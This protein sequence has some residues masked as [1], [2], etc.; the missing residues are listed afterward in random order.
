[1]PVLNFSTTHTHTYQTQHPNSLMICWRSRLRL[2][3]VRGYCGLQLG[4][5][6]APSSPN[7]PPAHRASPPACSG[8]HRV[9]EVV[10]P[11][12]L[13]CLRARAGMAVVL[14]CIH[15]ETRCKSSVKTLVARITTAAVADA[16]R[17]AANSGV[18]VGLM[19][20]QDLLTVEFAAQPQSP[21]RKCSLQPLRSTPPAPSW[22][23]YRAM[24][25]PI[26]TSRRCQS[27]E[28]EFAVGNF[29]RGWPVEPTG[30]QA[31]VARLSAESAPWPA[32]SPNPGRQCCPP[33]PRPCEPAGSKADAAD[34]G[35]LA[36]AVPHAPKSCIFSFT[37]VFSPSPVTFPCFQCLIF[38]YLTCLSNVS[39]CTLCIC[40]F[41]SLSHS[42]HLSSVAMCCVNSFCSMF[43][44]LLGT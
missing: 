20:P 2:S 43:S 7:C 11:R 10:T 17:K 19:R 15:N 37:C 25:V 40:V 33:S 12:T 32:P 5:T 21:A 34:V 44:T 13:Q 31:R 38:L 14:R 35:L 27:V 28:A 8:A 39:M 26:H 6:N 9:H 16:P 24:H 41:V 22:E 4:A 29:E 23:S 42:F 30:I 3:D 1:M 18:G 36:V